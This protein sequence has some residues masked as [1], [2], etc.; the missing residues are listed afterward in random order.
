MLSGLRAIC[1]RGNRVV[2]SLKTKY[3]VSSAS[4]ALVAGGVVRRRHRK[5]VVIRLS[6]A[7]EVPYNC[8]AFVNSQDLI[9]QSCRLSHD[10]SLPAQCAAASPLQPALGESEPQ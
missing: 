10:V 4:N 7:Q 1:G 6:G 5:P 8:H 2:L 9:L 3:L